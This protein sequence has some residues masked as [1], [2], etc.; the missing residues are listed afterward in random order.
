MT[1]E[2][3]AYFTRR[4]EAAS[5]STVRGSLPRLFLALAIKGSTGHARAIGRLSSFVGAPSAITLC[6]PVHSPNTN[7]EDPH[8]FARSTFGGRRCKLVLWSASVRYWHPTI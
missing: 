2:A 6:L 4:R 8:D 7:C 5:A 3:R 1:V